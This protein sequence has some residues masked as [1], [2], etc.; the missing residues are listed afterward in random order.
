MSRC[1]ARSRS[2]A[3]GGATPSASWRRRRA[4]SGNGPSASGG[5]WRGSSATAS[6]RCPTWCS[7][8]A[9]RAAA[10]RWCRPTTPASPSTTGP[11]CCRCS[12]TA[13]PAPTCSR[14]APTGGPWRSTAWSRST[15]STT[16]TWCTSTSRPT[17]S[18]SR[19]GRS[20][21]I[22]RSRARACIPDFERIALIDFA[23]SLV[24][25]ERL[26]SAL[27]IARQT[28]LRLPVAAPARGARGGQPRQPLADPAARLAL[29]PVQPG[30]DAAPLPARARAGRRLRL[31]GARAAR[32]RGRWCAAC[33]RRTTPSCRRCGRMPSCIAVTDDEL[34][35]PELAD[36]LQRGWPL[37]ERS[38]AAIDDSPTPVTRIAL[39]LALPLSPLRFVDSGDVIAIDP[40]DVEGWAAANPPPPQVRPRRR[41]WIA[42][43]AGLATAAAAVPLLGEAWRSWG[44]PGVA[45]RA[46]ATPPALREATPQRVAAAQVEHE[47]RRERE[48]RELG[49][50]P[51]PARPVAAAGGGRCARRAVGRRDARRWRRRARPCLPTGDRR[52]DT[53]TRPGS[54]GD[55]RRAGRRSLARAGGEGRRA[56]RASRPRRRRSARSPRPSRRR[57]F[58]PRRFHR[59]RR[60]A[61][62]R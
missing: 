28:E 3:S 21:S 54:G 26:D 19:S 52:G 48:E 43:L 7:S 14:T 9:A 38:V 49:A 34:R 60:A 44:E 16:C 57:R 6:A 22:P 30:G 17:T 4:T 8:T 11:R 23:F 2:R 42:G 12:A 51:A 36:S 27:P 1:S 55:E 39:P 29:R 58:A 35:D 24:S 62:S 46:V 32:R 20:T 56:E 31:D 41:A 33:S 50:G 59:R 5:S 15:R 13:R 10:R 47:E 61:A 25:G 37:G 18:A 40:S 45:A 53:R